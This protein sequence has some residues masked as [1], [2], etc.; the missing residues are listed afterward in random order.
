M[1][2]HSFSPLYW[3][4]VHWGLIDL[5]RQLG[6]PKLFWTLSPH[7]WSFL[8]PAWILDEMS[9]ELRGR[10]H[11]AAPESLH[12]THVL[13]QVV[14]G[15]VACLRLRS[16]VSL[17]PAA[18]GSP[19][20]PFV[21]GAFVAWS[22]PLGGA[23]AGQTGNKSKDPWRSHLLYALDSDG[24]P[25]SVHVFLRTEFQDGTRKAPTQDYHGS[26]RPHVHVLVFAP[27]EALRNMKLEESVLATRPEPLD[28]N[29]PLPG[30][31]EGSQLD[32]AGRSGWP[33]HMESSQWDSATD[34]LLLHHNRDDK[35]GMTKPRGFDPTSFPSW[36]PCAATRICR[37]LTTMGCFGPTWP[38][39]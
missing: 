23:L 1:K 12:I 19:A 38:N 6:Y 5:V 22:F 24:R 39:M 11:L 31:V 7:E 33:L 18:R 2:G 8:Y 28:E 14:R 15:T 25:H 36:K 10:L 21:V 4:A 17:T 35:A 29:D 34:T 32:R 13:L 3:K 30:I 20:V 27:K 26:G 9:K 37:W 16:M